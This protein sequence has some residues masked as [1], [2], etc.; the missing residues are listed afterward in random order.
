M[1]VGFK[2]SAVC[3]WVNNSQLIISFFF[4]IFSYKDF[5]FFY[6]VLNGGVK[7]H[8]A[9]MTQLDIWATGGN[10]W[11]RLKPVLDRNPAG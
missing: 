2:V 9:V 1:A 3:Y 5:F 11:S 4:L 10:R 6:Y 7:K 8:V